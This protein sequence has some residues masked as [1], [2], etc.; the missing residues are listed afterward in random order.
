M[1][2][3][4]FTR[5]WINYLILLMMLFTSVSCHSAPTSAGLEPAS[6]PQPSVEQT[7]QSQPTAEPK[8]N[9]TELKVHDDGSDL[10]PRPIFTPSLAYDS[11]RQKTILYDTRSSC[12]WE[13]DGEN[14][15]LIETRFSPPSN[16]G[17]QIVYDSLRKVTL[18]INDYPRA[19]EVWKYDGSN[20]RALSVEGSFHSISSGWLTATYIP[21]KQAVYVLGTCRKHCS[22]EGHYSGWQFDGHAWTE[23]RIIPF[24]A[25]PGEPTFM[26]PEIVYF[27][28]KET[29]V[30]Q[31]GFGGKSVGSWALDYDGVEWQIVK[32]DSSESGLND[33]LAFFDMVYDSNRNVIILFG[34][35]EHNELLRAETWE[36]DGSEWKE[37]LPLESPSVRYGHAM[38]YDQ[39]RDVVLLF[40]GSSVDNDNPTTFYETWEYDGITWVQ[41]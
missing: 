26:T 41:R 34:I 22:D 35:F 32:D 40:G 31:T 29:I 18:L 5:L 39:A 11:V 28:D 3:H 30:L 21:Q 20:W 27:E 2:F 19:G 33:L 37:M 6:S 36:Y 13:H 24:G 9:C 25:R 1:N 14:W 12:T 7:A 16:R 17:S 8:A 4:K 15:E 23:E 38:V 10:I